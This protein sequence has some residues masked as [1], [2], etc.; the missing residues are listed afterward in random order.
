M[1]TEIA[2][3]TAP[4]YLRDRDRQCYFC[5]QNRHSSS[6]LVENN[7]NYNHN[8]TPPRLKGFP[9]KIALLL[10]QLLLTNLENR[11]WR[12]LSPLRPQICACTCTMW[13]QKRQCGIA[14]T[15]Y[16]NS[17]DFLSSVKLPATDLAQLKVDDVLY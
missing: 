3:L 12:Q 5:E 8:P 9:T 16:S 17:P 6:A 13:N 7:H 15:L 11:Q 4:P 10:L 14:T 2:S 1:R